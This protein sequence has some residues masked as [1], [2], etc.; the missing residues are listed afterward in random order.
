[1]VL[2]SERDELSALVGEVPTGSDNEGPQQIFAAGK[3][4]Q[5]GRDL[6]QKVPRLG[7]RNH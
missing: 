2:R 1:M 5:C 4:S 3:T 6:G 7:V